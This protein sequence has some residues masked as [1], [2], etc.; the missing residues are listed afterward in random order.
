VPR[1]F[2][3]DGHV[4]GK[5][6]LYVLRDKLMPQIE[7]LGN[8]LPDWFQQVG[9][10]AH[11]AT[12]ARDWLNESFPHRIGRRGHVEWSPRSPEL[13]PLD[14]FFWGMLKESVLDEDYRFQAHERTHYQS[15]C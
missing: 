4:T 7:R 9:T 12:A 11:F 10:P 8:G 1:L 13:S 5:T 15:V 6:Y 2:L 14:F 3:F